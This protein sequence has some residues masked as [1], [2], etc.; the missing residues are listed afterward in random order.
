[1]IKIFSFNFIFPYSENMSSNTNQLEDQIS[2]TLDNYIT[3]FN[4]SDFKGASSYYDT[5]CA[6]I[7][8]SGLAISSS[9]EQLENLF[10]TV[11]SGLKQRGF[12][13]S[14]WIG[15]KKVVMLEDGRKGKGLL[16]AS[17][18]FKR[19]RKDGSSVEEWR[20]SYTFRKVAGEWKICTVH[21]YEFGKALA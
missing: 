9:Q 16:M 21:Q 14:E 20:A 18:D 10:S 19:L 7:S 5:P 11:V 2:Q 8:S 15:E 13:H 3:A 6:I 17:G 12:D 4:A 1:M